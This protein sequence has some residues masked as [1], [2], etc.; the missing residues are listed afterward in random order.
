MWTSSEDHNGA[1]FKR[2]F[3][4]LAVELR[5]ST[6]FKPR[7]FIYDGIYQDCYQ[8]VDCGSLDCE[9]CK[10][11]CI[12]DG[13]YCGPDP[14]NTFDGVKGAD[15]V[16]ENLR[17]MCIFKVLSK[18]TDAV[19]RKKDQ[20]KW[21]CYANAFANNCYGEDGKMD[22]SET[23]AQC[24]VDQMQDVGIDV[25]AVNTCMSDAGGTECRATGTCQQNTMLEG[26]VLDRKSVV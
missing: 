5:E 6:T 3:Q 16:K 23:F 7:Y 14:D 26:E 1:E 21:W 10:D 13:R 9:V 19:Q 25:A 24:A 11:L 17:Q 8:N 18:S 12:L 22:S 20:G 4:E 2:D 15:I